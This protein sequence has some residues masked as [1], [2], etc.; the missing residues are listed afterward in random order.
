MYLKCKKYIKVYELCQ[1]C[2]KKVSF[3]FYFILILCA[4]YVFICFMCFSWQFNPK[5]KDP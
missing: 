3:L 5:I 4:S 1:H 2:E